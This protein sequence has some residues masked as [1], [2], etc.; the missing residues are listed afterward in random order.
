MIDTAIGLIGLLAFVVAVISFA[1]GVTWFVV[2]VFPSGTKK[3]KT[4]D[5]QP[6]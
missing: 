1:A 3:K 5:P 2:K 4:P 6:S